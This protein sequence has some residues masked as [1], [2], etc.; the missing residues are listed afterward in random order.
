MTDVVWWCID[1]PWVVHLT[2]DGI[3][4]DNDCRILRQ[5]R[6]QLHVKSRTYIKIRGEINT[7][8]MLISQ[9]LAI[10]TSLPRLRYTRSID[11]ARAAGLTY[12]Q[13]TSR[14]RSCTLRSR[15]SR[16]NDTVSLEGRYCYLFW[17]SRTNPHLFLFSVSWLTAGCE[18]KRRKGEMFRHRK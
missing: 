2:S 16:F 9:N 13:S 3:G 5:V 10:S 6:C 14:S 1:A 15:L 8:Y 4:H 18:G 17:S 11:D 12:M 7:C